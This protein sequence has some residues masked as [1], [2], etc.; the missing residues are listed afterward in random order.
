MISYR[1]A[2]LLD[3]FEPYTLR[4]KCVEDLSEMYPTAKIYIHDDEPV[5]EMEFKRSRVFIEF[6]DNKEIVISSNTQEPFFVKGFKQIC[7]FV[8]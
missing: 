4:D 8:S 2:D 6:T 5:I 7:D 3:R 1:K